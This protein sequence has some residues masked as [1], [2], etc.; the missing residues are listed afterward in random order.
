MSFPGG[1]RRGSAR[2]GRK[3]DKRP[4][5]AYHADEYAEP[6]AESDSVPYNDSP[7][8]QS[9]GYDTYSKGSGDRYSALDVGTQESHPY[10]HEWSGEM[11]Q[12]GGNFALNARVFVAQKQLGFTNLLMLTTILLT[13]IAISRLLVSLIA[14]VSTVD[15]NMERLQIADTII[16]GFVVFMFMSI[17]ILTYMGQSMDTTY[18]HKIEVLKPYF[19]AV[20]FYGVALIF[21]WKFTRDHGNSVDRDDFV[22]ISKYSATHIMYILAGIFVIVMVPDAIYAHRYPERETYHT[23]DLIPHREAI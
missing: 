2:D 16:L 3:G 14:V 19:T 9:T 11:A 21:I 5:L 15:I 20:I 13:L 10:S 6:V 23:Y 1:G 4:S 17:V 22:E 8:G 18:R 7:N 12:S